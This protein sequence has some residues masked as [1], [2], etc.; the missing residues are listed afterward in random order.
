MRWQVRAWGC[1]AS[2]IGRAERVYWCPTM[3]CRFDNAA[4]QGFEKLLFAGCTIGYLAL[5]FL[6]YSL[7]SG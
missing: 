6:I 2:A 5:V 3:R 4:R 7:Q 1:L